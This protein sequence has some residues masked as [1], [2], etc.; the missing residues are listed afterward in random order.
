MV[1]EEFSVAEVITD[2]VTDTELAV[3][4][5]PVELDVDVVVAGLGIVRPVVAVGVEAVHLH[6]TDSESTKGLGS[7]RE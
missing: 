7:E 3:P 6:Q 4:H 2:S 5:V 1:L